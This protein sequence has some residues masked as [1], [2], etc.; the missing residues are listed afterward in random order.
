MKTQYFIIAI[1]CIILQQTVINAQTVT[2]YTPKWLLLFTYLCRKRQK[3]GN[4]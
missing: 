3:T 2:L 1:F 4:S